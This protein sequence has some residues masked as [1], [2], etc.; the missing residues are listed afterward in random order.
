MNAPASPITGQIDNPNAFF[1]QQKREIMEKLGDTS[2]VRILLN[3][4]WIAI[5]VRPEFKDMG[6]GKRLYR[7]ANSVAEDVFQGNAGL[8]IKMGPLAFKDDLSTE[9]GGDTCQVGDWVLYHRHAAGM[10]FKHNGV[11]CFMMETEKP[12]KAVLDRPDMVE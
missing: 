9:F 10:R 12:I 2:G 4:I 3:R 11:D 6:N 5:W 7:T 8:V 1:D